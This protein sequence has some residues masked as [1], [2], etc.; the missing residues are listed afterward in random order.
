MHKLLVGPI[1]SGFVGRQ[2]LVKNNK[3]LTSII[4]QTDLFEL[5]KITKQL[6]GSHKKGR[7]FQ[8]HKTPKVIL[9]YL[10]QIQPLKKNTTEKVIFLLF[11]Q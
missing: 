2:S 5:F 11:F 1:G 3:K 8:V 9:H 10:P 7:M 6:K 4:I